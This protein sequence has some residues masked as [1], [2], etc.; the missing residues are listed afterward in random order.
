M[1]N[2]SITM[3]S[4]N[5]YLLEINQIKNDI[6]ASVKTGETPKP[7]NEELMIVEVKATQDT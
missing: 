4:V 5:V 2:Y 7:Y 3:R 6:D 1:I